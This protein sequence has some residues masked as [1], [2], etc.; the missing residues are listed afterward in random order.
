M[1]CSS[2][3][4]VLGDTAGNPFIERAA[5]G[6]PV[7]SDHVILGGPLE[8]AEDAR[9]DGDYETAVNPSGYETAGALSMV[10]QDVLL[11][12]QN[13]S[14]RDHSV[15]SVTPDTKPSGVKP[16]VR[17]HR[18]AHEGGGGGIP[19]ESAHAR[20][21]PPGTGDTPTFGRARTLQALVD[22][23]GAAA[24]VEAYIGPRAS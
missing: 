16:G 2:S 4:T 22:R 20:L 24:Y 11:R 18:A 9:Q 19:L 21:L 10:Y 23:V 15:H 8:T 6:R 17:W 1:A 3:E 5:T 14:W 12:R 7:S 13:Q